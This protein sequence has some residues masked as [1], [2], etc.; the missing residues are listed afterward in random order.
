[1]GKPLE[2]RSAGLTEGLKQSLHI[3]PTVWIQHALE[4]KFP[5]LANT[6]IAVTS[7]QIQ[8][9][10]PYRSDPFFIVERHML[11]V[12]SDQRFYKLPQPLCF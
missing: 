3:A 5:R 7:S 6:L 4:L 8:A 11:T 1:M 10:I 2:T 9:A 12:A